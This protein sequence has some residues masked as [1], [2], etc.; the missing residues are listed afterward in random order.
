MFVWCVVMRVLSQV[1]LQG[2]VMNIKIDVLNYYGVMKKY[3]F[4]FLVLW[5]DIEVD[6]VII[7][8]GFFGINI[9]FE[10]V[11]QGIINVVVLEVCYFGYGGIGC[12]G[13][14]VMVG[15]GYDIEVVKKYVGKEGLEM[16]FKIVN[17]GVGIICECICK[18]NIDVD[19]VFGY[20]YFVYNQ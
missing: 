20:G 2:N 5:E 9:V 8:G 19:F 13:G 10:L 18:Y 15:I 16:L 11:E 7:G 17:F 3:Y 14:Q 4:Y 6:V 12:N 1:R